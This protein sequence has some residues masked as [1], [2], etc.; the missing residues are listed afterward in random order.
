MS[1]PSGYIPAII[2]NLNP[3]TEQFGDISR[4]SG[5]MQIPGSVKNVP[6]FVYNLLTEAEQVMDDNGKD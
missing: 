1:K 3:V 4:D 5:K 2:E 6:L